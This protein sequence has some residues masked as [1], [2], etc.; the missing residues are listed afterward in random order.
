MSTRKKVLG[1]PLISVLRL[2]VIMAVVALPLTAAATT[3]PG[4]SDPW[5][6]GMPNGSTASFGDV[7]PGQSPV[8]YGAVTPGATLTFTVTG[9]VD[10]AGNP[11]S[12]TPDGGVFQWHL[13]DSTNGGPENGIAGANIPINSLVG[14]FLS[15]TK[16]SLNPTPALL[17]FSVI[18]T[19]FTSLAPS[20]QQVFFIGD[21]RTGTGS[22]SVQ[23]FV[24][25]SEA[26]RLFLGTMDGF[27]WY[28]N[29]GEFT[30]GKSGTVPEPATIFL[31]G[32]G[33]ASLGLARRRA[34][35]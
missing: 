30:V 15:S 28:N 8:L 9:S 23:E 31:L 21:G 6:A 27:G 2:I 22:G 35:K 12:L 17:D 1:S 3:V 4:T 11:P 25:P 5:L 24:V 34:K 18:G 14:V 29:T 32:A 19:S 7:A 33:L 16:P 10:N 20:L 26:T 13:F